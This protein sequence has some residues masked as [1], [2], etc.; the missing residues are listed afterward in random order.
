MLSSCAQERDGVKLFYQ[1]HCLVDNLSTENI[2][3]L[4]RTMP[5]LAR[6]LVLN[7]VIFQRMTLTLLNWLLNFS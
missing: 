1:I 5:P 7:F 2:E 4:K 6:F 3:K